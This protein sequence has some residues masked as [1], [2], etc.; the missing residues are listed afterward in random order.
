M[1]TTCIALL[2]SNNFEILNRCE[3]EAT[4]EVIFVGGKRSEYCDTCSKEQLL[5]A[6]FFGKTVK[7]AKSIHEE[8][9]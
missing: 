2:P 5:F 7:Y 6:A 1:G 3:N 8:H 4:L 9:K